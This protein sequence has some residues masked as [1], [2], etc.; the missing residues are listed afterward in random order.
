MKIHLLIGYKDVACGK[1][2]SQI[3]FDTYRR[4][5]VTCE[6]CKRTMFYMTKGKVKRNRKIK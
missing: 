2:W 3:A 4:A 1:E 5:E 6:S